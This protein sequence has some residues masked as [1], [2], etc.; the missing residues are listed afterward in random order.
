MTSMTINWTDENASL[1]EAEA[2]ETGLSISDIANK[3][4]DFFL[5]RSEE[6]DEDAEDIAA[7]EKTLV[8]IQSGQ[9]KV[10]SSEE[11]W[12]QIGI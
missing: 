2:K 11:V 4:I 9:Q 1:I 5:G 3:A 10:W 8:E 6:Y 7:A 12:K